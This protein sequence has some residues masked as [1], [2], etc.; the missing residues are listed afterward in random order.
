VR[1]GKERR[2]EGWAE[3]WSKVTAVYI[4]HLSS[5]KTLQ[6]VALLLDVGLSSSIINNLHSSLRSS[7]GGK[8]GY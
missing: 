5:R 4:V 8:E 7:Q 1:S 3:D 2:T 6:L